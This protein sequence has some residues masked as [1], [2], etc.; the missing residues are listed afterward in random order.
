MECE[1]GA[2]GS[3]GEGLEVEAGVGEGEEPGAE[4]VWELGGEEGLEGVLEV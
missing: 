4:R 1:V 3:F 2:E